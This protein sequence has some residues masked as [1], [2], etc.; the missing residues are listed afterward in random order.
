LGTEYRQQAIEIYRS[1]D[2]KTHLATMLLNQGGAAM[3]VGDCEAA[4]RDL[5]AAAEACQKLGDADGEAIATSNL[6]LA[7]LELGSPDLAEGCFRSAIQQ[8]AW[9]GRPREEGYAHM[10]LALFHQ[11]RGSLTDAESELRGSIAL[12][13]QHGDSIAVVLATGLLALV[14]L[15]L[16]RDAAAR[17]LLEAA[18]QL[19]GERSQPETLRALDSLLPAFGDEPAD[20]PGQSHYARVV[21]MALSA[22]RART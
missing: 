21:S 16:G 4:A 9:L 17:E 8:L 22:F 5:Q 2:S 12:F 13:E 10:G 1:I 14:E 6:G 3:H 18:R 11:Q 15:E 7:Q 19:A 20:E